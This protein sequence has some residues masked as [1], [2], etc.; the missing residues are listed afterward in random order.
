MGLEMETLLV[1]P[2]KVQYTHTQLP[3]IRAVDT[4]GSVWSYV[5]EYNDLSSVH[6]RQVM[7]WNFMHE[8]LT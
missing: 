1:A 2:T 8:V 3:Y 4:I 7:W 6:K 5:H